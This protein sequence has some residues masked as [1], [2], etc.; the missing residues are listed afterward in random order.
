MLDGSLWHTLM[1]AGIQGI[2]L[3]IG[4]RSIE[5]HPGTTEARMGSTYDYYVFIAILFDLLHVAFESV[6]LQKWTRIN[7]F[8]LHWLHEWEVFHKVGIYRL[9]TTI[10]YNNSFSPEHHR[11][12]MLSKYDLFI[13]LLNLTLLSNRV[14][15]NITVS[16]QLDWLNCVVWIKYLLFHY[17]LDVIQHVIPYVIQEGSYYLKWGYMLSEL[18]HKVVEGCTLIEFLEGIHCYKLYSCG[19]LFF[20]FLI[21]FWVFC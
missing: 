2:V 6:L 1:W 19:H 14:Y 17:L 11:L 20:L 13:I 15:H 18:S 12:W 10:G 7:Q 4:S 16:E 8:L 9:F 5:H 21:S 3:F